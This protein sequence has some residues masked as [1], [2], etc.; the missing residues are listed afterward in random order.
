MQKTSERYEQMTFPELTVGA[1]DFPAKTSHLPENSS[2]SKESVQACFL[3]LQDLLQTSK[4]KT[5]PSCYFLRTLKTYLALIE[6][7][8]SPNFSLS[9]MKSGMTQNGRLSILPTSSLRTGSACS[10]LDILEE[11][12]ADR[13]F[14][15]QKAAKRIMTY[16]DLI[17]EQLQPVRDK[18]RQLERMLLKVNSLH[19]KITYQQSNRQGVAVG[20]IC[21]Q[22]SAKYQP[23]IMLDRSRTLKANSHDAG[24][25]IFNGAECFIR[26][27]TPLECW[28]L[29]GWEDEDFFRA[30]FLEKNLAHKFNIAYQR[31]RSNPV[32]LMQWAFKHQK[33]SD[34]QLYK[35][36]GNGV[37][38]LVVKAIAEKLENEDK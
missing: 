37:T 3:Q 35:Q 7:L 4:K 10:L 26:K 13:Y 34:S 27:F 33:T 36:A 22:A 12:V 20:S 29:Q 8:T 11:D 2:D 23:G 1:Q 31:H 25:V 24:V 5:D 38:T 17:Q 28:R 30:F 6:G 19:K 14:L 18:P 32:R 9:W 16:R 15:S 21:T